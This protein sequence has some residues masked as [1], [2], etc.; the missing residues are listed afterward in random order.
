MRSTFYIRAL[1]PISKLTKRENG[2]L[3][4]QTTVFKLERCNLTIQKHY[5][6]GT[7]HFKGS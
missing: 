5:K 6:Q 1:M 4:H 3:L 2:A 7:L